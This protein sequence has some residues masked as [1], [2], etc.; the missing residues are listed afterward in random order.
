MVQKTTGMRIRKEVSAGQAMFRVIALLLLLTGCK[1]K[2]ELH[3]QLSESDANE[4]IAAL[5]EY[6]IPA[7]K[8][9]TKEGLSVLINE[10]DI[11]QAV[12][13]LNA[14]GLPRKNRASLGEVFRKEGMISSPLE[15]RARYVYA[16]SQELE[17]TLSQIQGV[18]VAR[19]HVVLP[20]KIAP[21]EPLQLSSAA[22]FIKHQQALDPDVVEPKVRR[23][24]ASSIP[25]LAEAGGKN[26]AVVFMPAGV[27]SY[28]Q[29]GFTAMQAP[30]GAADSATSIAQHASAASQYDFSSVGHSIS[31]AL[32][33]LIGMTLV[34]SS[35]KSI[36]QGLKKIF[37]KRN[38][39]V[40]GNTQ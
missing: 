11:A 30:R 1:E 16:L 12:Q 7:T 17:Y 20:E 36:N 18:I 25:G 9:T 31:I 38:S 37:K 5:V 8:H 28:E 32:L 10:Q 15:E 34:I 35:R 21:G 24:V 22:V 4:V 39:V 23:M 13:I 19:V 29:K 40:S 26:I 33:I 2:M 14:R 27:Q 6:H 3:S